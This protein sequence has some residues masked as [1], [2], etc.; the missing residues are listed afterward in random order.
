MR[1]RKQIGERRGSTVGGLFPVT[2]YFPRHQLTAL[3]RVS[4]ERSVPRNVF[5]REAVRE[6]LQEWG[7][8]ERSA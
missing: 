2:V 3:D 5:I 6:S 7:Y 8:L 4:D 1:Q